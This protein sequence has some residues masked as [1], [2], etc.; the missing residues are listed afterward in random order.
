M[1]MKLE[2][3]EAMTDVEE[4]VFWRMFDVQLVRDDGAAARGHLQAGRP[5]YYREDTTPSGLVIKEFPNGR[6]ELVRFVNGVEQTVNNA[7][8]T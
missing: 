5:V 3:L 7:S 8:V 4:R 2:N 1:E 6:R